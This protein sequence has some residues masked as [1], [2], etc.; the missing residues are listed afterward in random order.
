MKKC[1]KC[2]K[3]LPFNSFSRDKSRK[4]GYSCYCKLCEKTKLANY[5]LGNKAKVNK[6]NLDN[7]YKNREAAI[8]RNKNWRATKPNYQKEYYAKNSSVIKDKVRAR[9]ALKKGNG[10][11]KVSIKELNTLYNSAC[12]YCGST[13]RIEIDHIIPIVKG[14]THS[15]GNLTSA[16]K[17]CNA[18]KNKD[19]FTVWRYKNKGRLQN[20]N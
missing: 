19:F 18:S 6:R 3:E 1:G 16:C 9:D 4:S 15:I 11:F 5:Y 10:I 13:E 17:T 12:V 14:G 20:G 8:Q 2:S 7:H